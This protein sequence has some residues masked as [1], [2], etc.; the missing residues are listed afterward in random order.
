[1]LDKEGLIEASNSWNIGSK[2]EY[3]IDKILTKTG[4]SVPMGKK[5][6]GKS[7][8]LLHMMIHVAAGINWLGVPVTK[9]KVL[10]LNYDEPKLALSIR[11]NKMIKSLGID[12]PENFKALTMD[13]EVCGNDV[14]GLQTPASCAKLC[15]LID[16]F[17]PD[18]VV[19]DSL[20]KVVT[21]NGQVLNVDNLM[22]L[23]KRYPHIVFVP[24]AHAQEKNITSAELFM[25]DD[26]GS[27][28]AGTAQ[29]ARDA[30]SY[31]VVMGVNKK[32]NN[33]ELDYIC[34]R[35]CTKRFPLISKSMKIN[36][37]QDEDS[38]AFENGGTYLPVPKLEMQQILVILGKAPG[39][40]SITEIVKIAE[41]SVSRVTINRYIE[42]L[43]DC[44]WIGI[45]RRGDKGARFFVLTD[46]GRFYLP[47]LPVW[48]KEHENEKESEQE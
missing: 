25:V 12:K 41:S 8:L 22:I 34:L 9:A 23:V 1:M 7:T 35:A 3:Y 38:M 37:V 27:Y 21:K 4:I 26:P 31:F 14:I 46:E 28:M 32:G 29:L 43:Y 5:G 2:A 17:T 15:E 6:S 40:M 18:I 10:W 11:T 39:E 13:K 33:A 20:I 16:T 24:L 36:V 30:D 42:Q 44:S 19:I 48:Q 45:A 47:T